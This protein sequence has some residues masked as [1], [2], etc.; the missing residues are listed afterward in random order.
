MFVLVSAASSYGS[1]SLLLEVELVLEGVEV[2]KDV[3]SL[4]YF[5]FNYFIFIPIYYVN[6]SRKKLRKCLVEG[7]KAK[8]TVLCCPV[9]GG[10]GSLIVAQGRTC[11]CLCVLLLLSPGKRSLDVSGG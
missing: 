6:L 3:P 4:F 11:K 8:R 1:S 5:F 9:I 2:P 10:K 7:N